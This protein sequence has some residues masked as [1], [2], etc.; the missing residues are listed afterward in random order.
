MLNRVEEITDEIVAM[1]GGA[2]TTLGTGGMV[3]KIKAAK[4]ATAGGTDMVIA[5]G[6]NPQLLYSIINGDDIGTR[7]VAKKGL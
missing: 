1:T 5:N 7:F 6:S 2:G 4:I 3:T